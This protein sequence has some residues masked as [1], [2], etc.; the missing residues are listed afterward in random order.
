MKPI[1]VMLVAAEASGDGLGA[2]LAKYAKDT[3]KL[4]NKGG[5]GRVLGIDARR[6]DS[7]ARILLWEDNGGSSE[8]WSLVPPP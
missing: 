5:D 6:K 8:W 7:G 4:I 1:T 3:L 2:G